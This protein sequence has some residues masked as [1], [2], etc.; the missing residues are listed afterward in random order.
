MEDHGDTPIWLQG[1]GD[2]FVIDTQLE[3]MKLSMSKQEYFTDLAML[4]I[5]DDSGVGIHRGRVILW[6]SAS[7]G[8][9][10]ACAALANEIRMFVGDEVMPSAQADFYLATAGDWD[11]RSLAPVRINLNAAMNKVRRTNPI[12]SPQVAELSTITPSGFMIVRAVG[13]ALS[14]EGKAISHRYAGAVGRP[15]PYV[16][17][18]P[19]A[20]EIMKVIAA[21][22]PWA[23]NV[24]VQLERRMAVSRS[25]GGSQQVF[26]P[27][28]LLGPTGSGKTSLAVRLAGLFGRPLSVVA[29]GG[30][31]DAGGVAPV[32]RGWAASKPCGPFVAAMENNCCDPAI[33]V[34]E[35]DKSPR[36]GAQ[37]GSITGTLLSMLDFERPYT[38]SCLMAPVDMS[39]MMFMAT[40]N[41]LARLSPQLLGRFDV[42]VVKRPSP[43]HFTMVLAEMRKIVAKANNSDPSF[44]P[45]LDQD[46]MGALHSFFVDKRCS[47]REFE[48]AFAMC[49]SS[50][51]QRERAMPN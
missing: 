49:L 42:M 35:I 37:N 40:A 24:G 5:E 21:E 26:K 27:V 3:E 12:G 28:L 39:R 31:S 6:I 44:L 16:G 9:R 14:N 8:D 13:D 51:I 2:I 30:T 43:E 36:E 45:R 41:D 34:D 15:L 10:E 7:L 4:L 1:P 18:V 46:E 23:E 33:L 29:A 20:G 38:D 50:A 17:H 22:F 48:S 32:T 19:P 47:L 25:V 11:A